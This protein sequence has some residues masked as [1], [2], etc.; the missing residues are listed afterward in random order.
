MA[1]WYIFA[2]IAAVLSGLIPITEK[3]IL[4]GL[5]ALE[6]SAFFAFLNLVLVLPLVFYADMRIP[7]NVLALIFI[8]S[9]I[10]S[11]A[12]YNMIRCV[13]MA[14]VSSIS[15]L[16]NLNSAFLAVLAYFFLGENLQFR[17]FAGIGMMILGAYVMEME[18]HI[19][20]FFEPVKKMIKS[21]IL[22]LV[23]FSAL[24]YP[25]ASMIDKIV[26]SRI[27]VFQY[28]VAGHFF[29]FINFFAIVIHKNY[30]IKKLEVDFGH[31]FFWI[32][33]S[34][35]LAVMSRLFQAKAISIAY[36]A[37]VIP[38]KRMDSLIATILGGE[39]FH[40]KRLKQKALAATI[41]IFGVYLLASQ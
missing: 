3:K 9:A 7:F 1:E 34:S 6:F 11:V 30:S 31:S 39:I 10:A 26:L 36:V 23:L 29:L 27:D 41:M 13:K 14:P 28:V 15:P 32:L 25:I 12:F 18:G 8:S 24:L 2:I 16:T 37:L 22:H 40:E 5:D 33:L 21:K 38:I 4:R 20:D 19:K 35:V 17:H